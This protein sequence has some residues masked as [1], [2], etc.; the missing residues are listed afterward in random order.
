MKTHATSAS[1]RSIRARSRSWDSSRWRPRFTAETFGQALKR[2][3]QPIKVKLLDQSLVAGVGNIYAS[4]ALFRAGI[5][6]KRPARRLTRAEMQRLWRA[7]RD[8]LT[9]AIQCGS[10]VPLSF[11]G[12]GKSDGL[13]Y[14][15]RAPGRMDYYEERLQVYDRAGR[16]CPECGTMIKRLV[17]AARST[18]Y[19]PC[20]QPR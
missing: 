2:S 3:A 15:G 12:T 20:C 1:S 10:T 7:I 17:Q 8:V 6:P 13:F 14:F 9:Q 4:E 18:F 5:S 19:C 16:A 11:S